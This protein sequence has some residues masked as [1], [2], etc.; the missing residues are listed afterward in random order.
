MPALLG[1]RA[2]SPSGGTGPINPGAR[3]TGSNQEPGRTGGNETDQGVI[4]SA[5]PRSPAQKYGRGAVS[6]AQMEK[7]IAAFNSSVNDLI[8]VMAPKS[9]PLPAWINV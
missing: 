7:A 1:W 3:P 8:C 2:S 4:V 6:A 5:A 9:Y